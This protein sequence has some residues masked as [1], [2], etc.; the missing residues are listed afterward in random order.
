MENLEAEILP[1]KGAD[2][3]LSGSPPRKILK[4]RAKSARIRTKNPLLDIAEEQQRYAKM[5]ESHSNL[6]DSISM[7]IFKKRDYNSILDI[8]R[9]IMNRKKAG[10]VSKKDQYRK[11]ETLINKIKEE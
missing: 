5:I 11:K 9:K 4:D 2:N 1:A 10:G 7:S 3:P 6:K 8:T